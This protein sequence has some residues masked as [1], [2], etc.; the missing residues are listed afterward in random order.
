MRERAERLGGSLRI[1]SRPGRGTTVTAEVRR[2]EFD[3][4]LAEPRPVVGG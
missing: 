3:R 2:S 1:E 4:N